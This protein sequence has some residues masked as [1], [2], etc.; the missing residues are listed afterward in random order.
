MGYFIETGR[1]G[2]KVEGPTWLST[3]A[4]EEMTKTRPKETPCCL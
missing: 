4:L 3:K 2:P 1:G